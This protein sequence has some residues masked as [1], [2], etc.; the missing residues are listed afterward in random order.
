LTE[1]LKALEQKEANTPK[2]SRW[3]DIIK[4]RAEVSQ[5]EQNQLHKESTKSGAIFFFE[6]IKKIDKLIAVVAK[7]HRDN[8]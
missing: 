1:H 6:K 7:G 3:Q 4:L 8:S 2:K 5:V